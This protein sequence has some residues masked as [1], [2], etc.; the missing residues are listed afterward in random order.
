[1]FFSHVDTCMHTCED[2][3]DSGSY[4]WSDETHSYSALCQD[5]D[6]FA[7]FKIPDQLTNYEC[8]DMFKSHVAT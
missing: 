2:E 4:K 6:S 5:S 7:N 8:D 1:M 3:C